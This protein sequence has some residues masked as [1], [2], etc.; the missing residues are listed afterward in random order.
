MFSR[1]DGASHKFYGMIISFSTY[2]YNTYEQ[3]YLLVYIQT[4]LTTMMSVLTH[5]THDSR[6]TTLVPLFLA[7]N[8]ERTN[9]KTPSVQPNIPFCLSPKRP[10]AKDSASQN[11]KRG[12]RR[13]LRRKGS[14]SILC[15]RPEER[16]SA[17]QPP[18]ERRSDRNYHN[19]AHK[20]S[21][22]THCTFHHYIVY[23]SLHTQ[24]DIIP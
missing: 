19:N 20:L 8:E 18:N 13:F 3:Y 10:H 11:W 9:K 22:S 7:Q 6:L 16:E 1:K 2:M 24:F 17:E 15:S 23:S 4:A 21:Q 5:A 12:V 14:T